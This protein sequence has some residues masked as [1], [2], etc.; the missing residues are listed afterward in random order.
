V[1]VEDPRCGILAQDTDPELR[2]A[3]VAG[4][5][6]C[7]TEERPAD[8]PTTESVTNDQLCDKS[9]ITGR[10]VEQLE[11]YARQHH[12]QANDLIAELSDEDFTGII[13]T[14]HVHLRQ[15]IVRYEFAGAEARIEP[16]FCVRQLDDTRTAPDLV[17]GFIRP[18]CCD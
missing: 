4:I 2:C 14:V 12:H 1:E 6:F 13:A 7:A 18:N 9:V 16:S 8:A 17:G 15:V 11:G 5:P 10:L 3:C